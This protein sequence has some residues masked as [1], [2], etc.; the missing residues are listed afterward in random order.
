MDNRESPGVS[1]EQL[2]AVGP[3][4]PIGAG[5]G[6]FEAPTVTCSH[7]QVVVV[8]NPLRNRDRAYCAKCDHYICDTCG[9]VAAKTGICRSFKQIIDEVLETALKEEVHG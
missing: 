5:R 7:C 1:D 8:I 3:P 9:G 6:M 4:L 2:R